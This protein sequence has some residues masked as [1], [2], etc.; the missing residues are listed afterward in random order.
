MNKIARPRLIVNTK[1]SINKTG[2]VLIKGKKM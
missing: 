2:E 1:S